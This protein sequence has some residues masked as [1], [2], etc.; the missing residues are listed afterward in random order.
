VQVHFADRSERA[1]ELRFAAFDSTQES[2]S[3]PGGPATKVTDAPELD[4]RFPPVMV[5]A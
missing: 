5:H 3:D 2:V 1:L 4:E